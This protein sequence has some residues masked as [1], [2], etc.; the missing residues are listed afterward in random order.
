ML[1]RNCDDTGRSR[2]HL[3]IGATVYGASHSGGAGAELELDRPFGDQER[4][5]LRV[6]YETVSGTGTHMLS[7]GPR[8]HVKDS[9][10]F[11]L[12]AVDVSGTAFDGSGY[13]SWGLLGGVGIEGSAGAKV[14]GVEL[15]VGA[16]LI[17]L[18]IAA[19]A[20][21]HGGN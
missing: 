8:L 7:F 15:G 9:L 4:V 17:V 16:A 12:D 1:V 5:G 2:L 14:V 18:L 20:T 11:E 3:R 13:D 21:S 19:L 6:G 10:Y